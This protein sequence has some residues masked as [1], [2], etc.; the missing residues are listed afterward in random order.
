MFVFID[1]AVT[2]CNI[3]LA[4]DSGIIAMH[5]EPV[6]RGHAEIVLPLFE[7]LMGAS[8]KTVGDITEIYVSIG[9]G[10]F[11]GLRVGLAT[12]R[13]MGFSLGVPVHGI[14]SF[15]TFSAA[16][17]G[18]KNRMVLVETKRDDYYMKILDEHHKTVIEPCC[19]IGRD[20]HAVLDAHD[21]VL[22]GDA[23]GRF[24]DETGWRGDVYPQSMINPAAVAQTIINNGFEYARAAAFYIRDAD[25][26]QPKSITAV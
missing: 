18:R 17:G 13:F 25:V 14:T 15:Q 2:G 26:S 6:V 12:A 22:T 3:V 20:V 16:I 11:T 10:S 19:V 9:P 21:C 23:A 1:T 24:V 4:D 8:G 7:R 5:Q